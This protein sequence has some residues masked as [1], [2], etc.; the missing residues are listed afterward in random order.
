MNIQTNSGDTDMADKLYL[1][2]DYT[3]PKE[4]AHLH[5]HTC[6]SALDGVAT[7]EQ[8]AEQCE[9]YGHP[10]MAVTEHGH[11]ASLPD[12]LVSFKKHG[13]KNIAGCEIYYNDYELERR[14]IS[15][16]NKDALKILRSSDPEKYARYSRNRHLTILCKN[17]IGV[18]NL[19][20]LTT[21]A[22]DTGFYYKPRIWFEKL[23]EYKEGL[24]V[25]SGCLN[26]PVAHEL[27]RGQLVDGQYKPRLVSDDKRGALDYVKK[28]KE[29]F[30]E[31]Y[32]IELQMPCIEDDVEV[33][34]KL[35]HIA[36]S[37]K[38]KWVLANDSHYL[39]REDF[40]TQKLMMAIDQG[41]TINDT[42]LFHVNS[43]EQFFKTRA[44]LWATF[45]NNRYSEKVS[46]AEF[47][48]ACDNTLLILERCKQFKPDS[49]PKT[50][51]IKNDGAILK[52]IVFNALKHKGL[53]K[54]TK[55]YLVDGKYVTYTE[56]AEIELDRFVSKGFASYFLITQ[57]IVKFGKKH[58]WPFNPRGSAGGSLVNYLLGISYIDPLMWGLSPSRFLADARGG[59]MLNLNMPVDTV[60]KVG[61][62][63]TDDV[64]ESEEI[65]E[66][67]ESEESE[68]IETE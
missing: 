25:L 66:I 21:Q 60:A 40:M 9:N 17:E 56:Q 42:S 67:E 18:E 4:F 32:F 20:K 10:G 61:V 19:I 16:T 34:W 46:D 30:G 24:I 41:K 59:Y 23:L 33:F 52:D 57:D 6:Y 27:R 11:M 38:I 13:L 15:S 50:P 51:I 48:I 12:M 68:E 1:P 28:F 3:G 22:Y 54:D 29:A 8:Y 43:D 53:D 64:D 31:D 63:I 2:S 14:V 7:P 37:L 55:K 47:E 36:K 49:N 65:E 39:M 58:G 62:D 44:E 35:V 5:S 45:K 26:G